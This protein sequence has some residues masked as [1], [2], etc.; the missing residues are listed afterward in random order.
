MA[1]KAEMAERKISITI[2]HSIYIQKPREVVLDYTQD[3]SH[4]AEC[5]NSVVEPTTK[6][7]AGSQSNIGRSVNPFLISINLKLAI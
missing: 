4:R 1:E 2:H 3:Y 7:Y 6:G 5:D